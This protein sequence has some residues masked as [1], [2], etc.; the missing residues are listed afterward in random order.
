MKE[1]FYLFPTA[2]PSHCLVMGSWASVRGL[3]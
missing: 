1:A 2:E 3:L